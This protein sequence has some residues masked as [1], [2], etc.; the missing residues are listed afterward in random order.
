M[1]ILF[2]LPI[3]YVID[4]ISKVLALLAGTGLFALSSRTLLL[5]DSFIGILVAFAG[6]F[7]LA[8]MILEVAGP[9]LAANLAPIRL[10]G[11]YLALFGSCFGISYGMS[12]IAAGALLQARLPDVIWA[13]QLVAAAI[14]VLCL[15]SLAAFGLRVT[16]N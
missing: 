3:S 1:V 5:T 13:I 4:R 6:F 7:T 12:P 9:A 8:E 11:T 14:A 2:Q 10:R 15:G 16:K